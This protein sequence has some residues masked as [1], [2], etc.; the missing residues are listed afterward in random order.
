MTLPYIN[1]IGIIVEDL[2]QTM[3]LF[4]ELFGLKPS[5][6]KELPDVGL[7]IGH[8]HARNIDIEFIQY[9]SHE[10]GLADSVMG[11]KSGLNHFSFHVNDIAAALTE[12]QGKGVK[13]MEG[14][15]RKGSQGRVAFFEPDTTAHILLEIGESD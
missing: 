2:D 1:H 7:R 14:F 3:I 13:V 5:G 11:R 8:M 4:K 9:L 12:L 15:P 10:S 6:I